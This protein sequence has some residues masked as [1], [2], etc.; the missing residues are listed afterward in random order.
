MLVLQVQG[1]D[2]QDAQI[3]HDMFEMLL[4]LINHV[5]HFIEAQEPYGKVIRFLSTSQI[6]C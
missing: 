5:F 4:H 6:S 3:S 2:H 1:F